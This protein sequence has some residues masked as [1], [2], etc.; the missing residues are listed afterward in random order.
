MKKRGEKDL[1]IESK[2]RLNLFLL[3]TVLFF[4]VSVMVFAIIFYSAFFFNIQIIKLIFRGIIVLIGVL[5][6]YILISEFINYHTR[7]II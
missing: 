2:N 7:K 1:G 6:Y 5:V 3:G 4:I